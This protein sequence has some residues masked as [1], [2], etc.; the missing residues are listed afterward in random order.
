MR[1]IST[2]AVESAIQV[3]RAE[4]LG[5]QLGD[6]VYLSGAFWQIAEDGRFFELVV[7]PTQAAVCASVLLSLRAARATQTGAR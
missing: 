4:L 1:T 5:N 2:A 7:D 6:P 3:G